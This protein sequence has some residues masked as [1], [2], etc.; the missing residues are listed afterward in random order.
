MKGVTDS[1]NLPVKSQPGRFNFL[2]LALA[3]LALNLS[4]IQ[5]A[6]AWYFTNTGS[7]NTPREFHTAT[8]LSNGKVL[9]RGRPQQP[10]S[11][12]QRRVV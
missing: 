5:S 1:S 12:L 6:S 2:A 7:L 9:C 11:S 3:A 10:C 8:L 4:L